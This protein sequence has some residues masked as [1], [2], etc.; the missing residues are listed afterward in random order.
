[1]AQ[2]ACKKMRRIGSDLFLKGRG[3]PIE[4]KCNL[5]KRPGQQGD[6][7][8]RQTDY[9]VQLAEKQKARYIYGLREGQF[10]RYYKD[11][12]RRKGPTGH[13]LLIALEC[14]LDNVVYRMGFASTRREARQLVKHK[15][16]SV[17]TEAG[18]E[19]QMINIPSYQVKPGDEIAIRDKAKGQSRI[20]AAV[21]V[22]KNLGF[23]E[24]VEVDVSKLQARFKQEPE[25]DQLSA[26]INEQLIVE[27][28]SK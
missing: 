22:A 5:S 23:P 25:R 13:N 19:F 11:A 10:R 28:Y 27:L 16:V 1:M 4:K 14:R 17:K 18:N 3:N 26:E 2:S 8:R 24:W 6:A 12:A 21:E 20:L 7:R 15:A 9:S